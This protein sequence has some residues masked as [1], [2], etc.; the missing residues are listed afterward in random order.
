LK[1]EKN[2]GGGPSSSS[3]KGKVEGSTDKTRGG[4]QKIKTLLAVRPR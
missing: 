4:L 1:K 3:Q 2:A